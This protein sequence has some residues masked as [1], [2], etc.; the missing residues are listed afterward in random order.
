MCSSMKIIG[1]TIGINVKNTRITMSLANMLAKRRMVSDRTRAR[2]L[3]IS[4]GNISGA[5]HH[6]GPMKFLTYPNP[7]TRMPW[8]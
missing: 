6:T 8:K 1:I 4:M 5:S 2:W 3:N 7:F